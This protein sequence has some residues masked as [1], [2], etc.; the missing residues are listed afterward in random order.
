[1]QVGLR[2]VPEGDRGI[3]SPCGI[4]CLGC[5]LYQEESLEAAKTLV[6]IW[7]GW[8]VEDTAGTIGLK[9]VE[10]SQVVGDPAMKWWTLG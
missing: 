8:N 2:D 9:V 7:N 1:M 6:K 10:V 3:L 5:E 4:V